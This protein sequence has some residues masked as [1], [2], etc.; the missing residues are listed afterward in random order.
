MGLEA[1][2]LGI[3]QITTIVAMG[4]FLWQVFNRRFEGV[5]ERF[6]KVDGKFDK[7][8]A[9]FDKVVADMDTRFGRVDARFDKL[10][11]KVGDLAKD[12]QGLARELSEFR[13]EMR[14]RLDALPSVV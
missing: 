8:D 12:H 7:V 9:R 11:A 1:I 10:E 5:D 4:V 2:A 13:G 6:D 14:G 3:T